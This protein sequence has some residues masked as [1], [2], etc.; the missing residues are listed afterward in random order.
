MFIEYCVRENLPYYFKVFGHKG[1]TDTIVIYVDTD[2][3][4]KRIIDIIE[5]IYND[6]KVFK[7][8]TK[9]PS[10]H[11]YKVSD[12]IGYGFEPPCRSEMQMFSSFNLDDKYIFSNKYFSY[13]LAVYGNDIA[14]I[15]FNIKSNMANQLST[16]NNT[17]NNK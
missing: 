5:Q 8:V 6:K 13:I 15:I 4:L 11:L 14:D 2:E 3:H 12:Y 16:G 17:N 7:D 9:E 10:P 1:Q